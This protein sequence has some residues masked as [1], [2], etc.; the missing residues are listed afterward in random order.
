MKD[1]KFEKLNSTTSK[2]KKIDNPRRR[3]DIEVGDSLQEEFYPQMKTMHWDNDANFSVR[4]IDNGQGDARYGLGI[5][6]Y[7]NGPLTAKF[8]EMESD[9]EDNAF[10]FDITYTEKPASNVVRFTTQSKNLDFLYQGELTQEELDEGAVRPENVIGSYAVYHSTKSGNVKDGYEYRTGKAFHIYRPFIEDSNGRKEW[11]DLDI[12][13]NFLTITVPQDFLDEAVYPIRLDPTFGYDTAGGTTTS[14]GSDFQ[15]VMAYAPVEA[16][17]T[18]IS[19]YCAGDTGTST[20]FSLYDNYVNAYDRNAPATRVDYTA[21]FGH[22]SATVR[23]WTTKSF[24]QSGTVDYENVWMTMAMSTGTSSFLYAYDSSAENLRGWASSA[25][26]FYNPPPS[27]APYVTPSPRKVS[28]Y[29]TYSQDETLS[30]DNVD[31]VFTVG[32]TKSLTYETDYPF[33]HEFKDDFDDNSLSGNWG[34][35][36]AGGATVT[37]TNNE[38]QCV[39]SSSGDDA[40]LYSYYKYGIDESYVEIN[41]KQAPT[42]T[43][44]DAYFW[45]QDTSGASRMGFVWG[46]GTL[47]SKDY[48]YTTIDSTSLSTVDSDTWLRM[49][50]TGGT[51][52][53]EYSTN[54]RSSWTELSSESLSS[55]S[56]FDQTDVAILLGANAWSSSATAN[57]KWDNLNMPYVESVTKSLAYETVSTPTALTKGLI[58]A[59]GESTTTESVTKSIDYDVITTPTAITQGLYYEVKS[60]PS[61]KTKSL[62]YEVKSTPTAITKSLQYNVLTTPSAITKSLD[63]EVTSTPAAKTKSLT[64][65]I[66]PSV[67]ITKGLTYE[68]DPLYTYIGNSEDATDTSTYT[69]SSE[70]LG[71][72]DDNRYIIVAINSRK[73]GGYT[74]IS[75]VS[76]GGVSA[77]EVMQDTNANTNTDV[78]G[79]F[80]AK[81]PTGTTGDIVVTFGATMARCS[82]DVY[83]STHLIDEYAHDY[84]SAQQDDPSDGIEVMARGFVICT[85]NTNGSTSVTWT[86]ADEDSDSDIET[87]MTYSSASKSYLT[88]QS[89]LTITADFASSGTE[90]L[91]IFSSWATT[92]S[93]ALT[94]SLAYEIT[95]TP[96]AT[97]KGLEYEVTSTPTP[98]SKGLDYEVKSTPT[99]KTKNLEYQ[100]TSTHSPITKS[101]EYLV[102]VTPTAIT[103]GLEYTVLTTPTETTKSLEYEVK[104]TPTALTKSLEYE[105]DAIDTI[106]IE[107]GLEYRVETTP[108]PSTKSLNYEVTSTITPTKALA[109]ETVSTPAAITKS[110]TYTVITTPTGKT[111]DLEYAVEK[112][113]SQTKDLEY[114]VTSTVSDETLELYYEVKNDVTLQKS[115]EYQATNTA[116]ALT[117]GLVYTIIT[118]PTE[119]TKGLEYEVTSIDSQTKELDYDVTITPAA[120][121]SSLEY[122]VRTTSAPVTKGLEYQATNAAAAITKGLEYTVLTTPTAS[123]KSL[124]YAINLSPFSREQNSSLPTTSANLGTIFSP[125]EE[126]DVSTDDNTY[127]D[128]DGVDGYLIQQFKYIHIN[129]TA[130]VKVTWI[131]KTSTAPSTNTVYLQIYNYTTASWVELDSNST[132]SADTE[133]KLLGYKTGTDYYDASNEITARVYQSL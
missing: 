84:N 114:L 12:S 53:W 5:V 32:K 9:D 43:Q 2:L 108:S 89:D 66:D 21:A 41:F 131:G 75:S 42:G 110:L 80:I 1:N 104:S 68:V 7:V 63:Y 74:S 79:I 15:C 65:E 13:G 25:G 59:I 62:D 111:K 117:K 76:I 88:Y 73:A 97:T 50:E 45:L 36:T 27:T 10:E 20:T 118:T 23:Q 98:T 55:Y 112:T 128:I 127:V 124:A 24:T 129:D 40:Q 22:T 54:D 39:T 78:S 123:T 77:T 94:K 14:S 46:N 82:L 28:A 100:V 48:N 101:L 51:L 35:Y 34:T 105:V 44:V 16:D 115:L 95:N 33:I 85:A 91:G 113:Y 31:F 96:A 133:F 52:Y 125:G 4:L 11:C 64:Y 58:Y 19:F 6:E 109:Y 60:T 122:F 83:R 121:T 47:Y 18:S 90:T 119:T 86:G 120:L 102:T 49:R 30:T 29:V 69:F 116:A 93:T 81:V 106:K 87:Y 107:K 3:V 8:Y 132:E 126:T 92:G 37:E 61:A 67:T 71:A 103:K 26:G 130:R 99:A 56:S 38:I 17:L 70:S 57:V 72:A